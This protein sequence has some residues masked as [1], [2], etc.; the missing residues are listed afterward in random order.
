MRCG[1]SRGEAWKHRNEHPWRKEGTKRTVKPRQLAVEPQWTVDELWVSPFRERRRYETDGDRMW[2]V[3]EKIEERERPRT[4]VRIFDDW[5]RYLSEGHSEMTAFCRRY[6]LRTGDLDSMCFVLTGL[7]GVDFRM[8]YQLKTLDELL[9]YTD[10]TPAE[11]A[12]RSGFGSLNNLFLTTKREY[13]QAPVERRR[14]IQKKG[15]AG[16]YRLPKE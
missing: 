8:K 5:L 12:R 6:G 15:D 4:G 13:N 2:T 14:A 16:R 7:R 3:W 10:L 1:A 9:R 11:V